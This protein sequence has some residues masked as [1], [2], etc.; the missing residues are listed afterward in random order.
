ML[1]KGTHSVQENWTQIDDS[2]A[3]T[4]STDLSQKSFDRF[5]RYITSELGIKMPDSKMTMV[6]SRLLRRARELRLGSIDEYGEYFFDSTSVEEREHF[7]NAITTNKTDFF[8]EPDHFDYLVKTALPTLRS[9][10][11]PRM[12]RLNVWSAAC[13]S[14]QEPYTL[15]MVLSEYALQNVGFNFAILGTDISTKVLA[16]ARRAVYEESI[17]APVPAPFRKKY[18]L[19]SKDRGS[20]L[21]RISPVLREKVSFHALNFM[22][23]S[24]RIQDMF[25]VVFCRNVLIYFDRKTQESV[26]CKICR[27]INPGGYLF[28]GHSES[29]AG[30]DV[31]AKQVKTAVF[32][33]PLQAER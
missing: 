21:V 18:L 31:P 15:A 4:V 28:V 6:Q 1:Q 16:Q 14:G 9:E 5:A 20:G 27:N 25:D 2:G 24:Y 13:S 23:D 8:R 10:A 30:M 33:M 7:I 26:I 32:R 29:L 19:R 22:N 3:R 11:D 17:T 12:S